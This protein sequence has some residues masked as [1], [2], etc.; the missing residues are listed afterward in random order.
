MQRKRV[1]V[2]GGVGLIGSHLIGKLLAR[3]EEVYCVDSR[4]LS[5]SVALR[6]QKSDLFHYVKH[7][8]TTPYT[9][10][11]DEIYNLTSPVRLSYDKQLPVETLKT[12]LLGS[13]NT[14]EIARSEFSRV[15]YG[16]SSSVYAPNTRLDI[17]S[18]NEQYA[19]IEGIRAAEVIHRSYHTEYGV[20]C[21]IARIFNTYGSGSDLRERRVIMRM[22]TAALQ[23][24]DIT[25]FGSG[26]QV[27]TF[28]WA[29]DIADALIA[30]M[31][32]PSETTP[33][34]VDLGSDNEISIRALAER[35]INLTG[36]RSKI[37][38]SPMRMGDRQNITPNLSTAKKLLGWQAKTSLNEGLMRTIDYAERTL[39]S[40]SGS[41]RTWVEIY[42]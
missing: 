4:D 20:D 15:V 21:R 31:D 33:R 27:R 17:D 39:S 13:I 8:I 36:S 29:G 5:A 19:S 35:I 28:C 41:S 11:C 24:R 16:S 2:L 7:N 42:S 18:R 9:I 1:V 14:L 3:G 6:E 40:Y 22:I 10:R 38:H 25:V 12:H 26:E 30:L 37:I 23:N 34:V 32:S